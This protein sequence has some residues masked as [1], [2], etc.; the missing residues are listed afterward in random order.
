M[1]NYDHKLQL[2]GKHA[3]KN[4]LIPIF[5]SEYDTGEVPNAMDDQPRA[6]TMASP[7]RSAGLCSFFTVFGYLKLFYYLI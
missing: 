7:W 6:R 1:T 5:A 2:P 4:I 3:K